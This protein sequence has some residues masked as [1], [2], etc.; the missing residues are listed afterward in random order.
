MPL[1]HIMQ[2]SSLSL[3]VVGRC[4]P[5]GQSW[6]TD[7]SAAPEVVEYFPVEQ[8]PEHVASDVAP[9]EAE[10][11]PAPQFKHVDAPK[12][13]EYLPATH[14]EHTDEPG[15]AVI[16]PERQSTHVSTDEAPLAAEYLPAAQLPAHAVAPS[17]D[18]YLPASHLPQ[19]RI[20]VLPVEVEY[21]PASHKE[22]VLAPSPE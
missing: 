13:P 12:R 10:N 9:V 20:D 7:A 8:S 5:A 11:L 22:H 18:E 19:V 14:G 17:T 16:M 15:V 21:L 6:H 3:P 1:S 2:S 4:L